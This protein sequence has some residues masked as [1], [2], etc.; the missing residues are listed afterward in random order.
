MKLKDLFKSKKNVEAPKSAVEKADDRIIAADE[1]K[2]TDP[3]PKRVRVAEEIKRFDAEEMPKTRLT[4]EYKEFL[5]KQQE[6]EAVI[7]RAA[8]EPDPKLAAAAALTKH[9][10]DSLKNDK[11]CGCTA[12]LAIFD[13]AE[14]T[15]WNGDTAVCPYCGSEAVIG[16]GS[17]C[18]IT[19][20]T[21]AELNKYRA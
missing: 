3:V 2:R 18:P 14:I 6:A 15:D 13:P 10:R 1:L 4:D 17:G 20:D 5:A 12:C 11:T 16:E 21:L 8:E 19:A 9:N 7:T